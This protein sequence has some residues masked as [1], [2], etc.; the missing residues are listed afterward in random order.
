MRVKIGATERYQSSG[1]VEIDAEKVIKHEKFVPG[2]K[3]A[4]DIGLIKM[5]AGISSFR[6]SIKYSSIT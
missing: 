6:E 2:P 3:H 4:N 5:K 1:F